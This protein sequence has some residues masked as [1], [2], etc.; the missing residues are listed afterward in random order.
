MERGI[1]ERGV[2]A[3]GLEKTQKHSCETAGGQKLV[4]TDASP[5]GTFE[6]LCTE[7][8]SILVLHLR[9]AIEWV[10]TEG[11]A[12]PNCFSALATT[13]SKFS[14]L[15]TSHFSNMTLSLGMVERSS[16]IFSTLRARHNIG[17]PAL[18]NQRAL[19]GWVCIIRGACGVCEFVVR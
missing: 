17:C 19:C 18:E 14:R 11:K 4:G 2:G 10:S 7:G 13:A 15:V 9:R 8:G 5:P 6:N 12:L 16:F 3:W 1:E